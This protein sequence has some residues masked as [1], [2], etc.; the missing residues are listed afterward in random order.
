MVDDGSP[1]EKCLWCDARLPF[2]P[3]IDLSGKTP[4]PT[5][6]SCG[7]GGYEVPPKFALYCECGHT[8]D[9]HG[10]V[11]VR[12]RTVL[13]AEMCCTECDCDCFLTAIDAEGRAVRTMLP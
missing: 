7:H 12:G 13:L 4:L 9:K 2:V 6:A 5:C 10:Q 11:V 8:F 1:Y 3:V